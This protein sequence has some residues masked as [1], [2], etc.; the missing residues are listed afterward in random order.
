MQ[1]KNLQQYR[2]MRHYSV[3]YHGFPKSLSATMDVELTYD[4]ATGKSFRIVSQSGSHLLC[5]KVLKRAVDSEAEASNTRKAA[6]LTPDNYRF[7]LAGAD[8]VN[9]RTAYVLQVD[10]IRPGKF[11]YKGKI[12]IDSKDFA[13]VKIEA[14]PAKNPSFWISQTEIHQSYAP[15]DGFWLPLRNRSETKVRFGGT[16]VFTIDYGPYFDVTG[17]P[18][19]PVLATEHDQSSV[20][21]S[22]P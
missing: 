10:P 14:E 1:T 13:L 19:T 22:Q 11:L 9:G 20:E 7:Q 12:W 5:E 8:T 18:L 16:A 15:A 21:D 17:Q 4:A 3:E 6:A 2:T